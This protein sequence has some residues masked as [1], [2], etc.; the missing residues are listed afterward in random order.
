MVN[1]LD[2]LPIDHVSINHIC[3]C[4]LIVCGHNKVSYGQGYGNAETEVV[5]ICGCVLLGVAWRVC[6]CV[7]TPGT[8]HNTMFVHYHKDM[9]L[10][11]VVSLT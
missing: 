10:I 8:F 4:C 9:M 3:A 1:G 2:M 7:C 6:V 5:H 11:E